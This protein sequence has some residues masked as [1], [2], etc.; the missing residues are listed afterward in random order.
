MLVVILR[1]I[2]LLALNLEQ[3]QLLGLISHA[4]EQMV[5]V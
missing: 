3:T 1:L 4:L 2:G 5:V